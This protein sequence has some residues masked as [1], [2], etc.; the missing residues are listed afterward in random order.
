MTPQTSLIWLTQ[1]EAPNLVV[2]YECLYIC[3]DHEKGVCQWE[4]Q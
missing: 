3:D 1:M 4:G 2:L